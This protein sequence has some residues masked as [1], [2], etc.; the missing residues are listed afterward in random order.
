MNNNCQ[1]VQFLPML[2][3]MH[4]LYVFL[5]VSDTNRW[6]GHMTLITSMTFLVFANYFF[7]PRERTRPL[8]IFKDHKNKRARFQA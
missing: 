3:R 8:Y 2:L 4:V 6:V 5:I 7:P 1:I